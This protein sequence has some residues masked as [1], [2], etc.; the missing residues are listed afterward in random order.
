MLH[1][2]LPCRI[3]VASL[4]LLMMVLDYRSVDVGSEI[5]QLFVD[6]FAERS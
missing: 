1:W 3:V 2:L 5:A 6:I 4:D